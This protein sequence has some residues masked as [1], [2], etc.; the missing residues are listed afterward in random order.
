MKITNNLSN[1]YF[2][3]YKKA[4]SINFNK[5][6]ILE[7]RKIY[8]GDFLAIVLINIVYLILE[9]VLILSIGKILN[10]LNYCI[11]LIGFYITLRI[12]SRILLSLYRHSIGLIHT[13]EFDEKGLYDKSFFGIKFL[14]SW[15]S[16]KGIVIDKDIIVILTNNI[17]YFILNKSCEEELIKVLKK[18]KKEELVIKE[19]V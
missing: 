15:N 2:D 3:Y 13:Y 10:I 14:F 16:I 11:L 9:I 5:K 6:L 19:E 1:N 4:L 12:I 8:R 17:C 18:Y 7:D